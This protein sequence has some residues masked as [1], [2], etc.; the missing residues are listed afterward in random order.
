M[1]T[2]LKNLKVL[3][4]SRVLAGPYCAQL[5]ADQGA[6]VIKVENPGTG[7]EN[8]VWGAR[9]SDGITANFHSVNRGKRGITLNLKHAAALDILKKLIAK[10]DVVIQ[11]FCRSP[12]S[13][14]A[15][16]TT[17]CAPSNPT[18]STAQ[19]TAMVPMETCITRRAMI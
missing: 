13:A 9:A 19:L 15:W 3:D 7:D 6:D 17:P 8:R 18:S 10:S 4:L 16:I 1:T 2:L 5:L 11:S 14:W 12:R